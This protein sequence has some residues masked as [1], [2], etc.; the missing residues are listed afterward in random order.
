MLPDLRCKQISLLKTLEGSVGDIEATLEEVEGQVRVRPFKCMRA[1]CLGIAAL[2]SMLLPM[3]AFDP[4]GPMNSCAAATHPL[5]GPVLFVRFYEGPAAASE[6][7][8]GLAL[9]SRGCLPW[10]CARTPWA[11]AWG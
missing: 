8:Q 9:A 6:R 3:S 7:R 2:C 1:A 4:R 5:Q 10:P 11:G